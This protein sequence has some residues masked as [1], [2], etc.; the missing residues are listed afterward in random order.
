MRSY[1]LAS[2]PPGLF[3]DVVCPL[4]PSLRDRYSCVSGGD[5]LALDC[6]RAVVFLYVNRYMADC[7]AVYLSENTER[8][9][10]MKGVIIFG[11]LFLV[12]AFLLGRALVLGR[13][14][15]FLYTGV[16]SW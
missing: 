9:W 12:W 5:C 1:D 3:L 7:L 15:R 11:T 2:L 14:E 16:K 13:K 10:T 4:H 8:E 6:Q